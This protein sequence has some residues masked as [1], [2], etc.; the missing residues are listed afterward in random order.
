MEGCLLE[1]RGKACTLARAR[2]CPDVRTNN[3]ERLSDLSMRTMADAIASFVTEWAAAHAGALPSG[4]D[5]LAWLME[6]AE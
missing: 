1:Y 3:A 4:D 5:V 6:D 2:E